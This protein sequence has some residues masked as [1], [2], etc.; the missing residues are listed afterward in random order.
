MD[1]FRVVRG[2]FLL[3]MVFVAFGGI[4][5]S[6]RYAAIF[7]LA[8]IAT[9]VVLVGAVLGVLIRAAAVQRR[10]HGIGVAVWAAVAA[11]LVTVGALTRPG[12]TLVVTGISLV[13][14]LGTYLSRRRVPA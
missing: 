12:L 8:V 1:T 4:L 2:G 7:Q 14:G 13:V 11:G 5:T 6:T 10:P 9:A 3:A